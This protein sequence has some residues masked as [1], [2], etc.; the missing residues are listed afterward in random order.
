MQTILP[1]LVALRMLC[2][3]PPARAELD[4]ANLREVL[5]DRQDPRGQSQAA[6][7][8]VQST[9]PGAEK[10]VRQGLR[11][12]EETEVFLALTTAVRLRHDGR[13]LDELLAALYA[14][15]ARVRQAV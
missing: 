11:Q 12:P 5:H 7:L 9:D 10:L 4:L 14:N 1:L 3:S 2:A 15:R 8:L 6:L 13:F